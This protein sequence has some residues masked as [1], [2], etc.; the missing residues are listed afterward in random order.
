MIDL[1][2][3][4]FS[5]NWLVITLILLAIV[6]RF[7]VAAQVFYNPGLPIFP[8]N[9]LGI[10]HEWIKQGVY[11]HP[12]FGPGY[13][14]FL[15]GL[16]WVPIP[17][18]YFV[19]FIVVIQL[20]LS[21]VTILLSYFITIKMTNSKRVATIVVGLLAID[22]VFII[23]PSFIFTEVWYTFLIVLAFY[24]ML[25]RNS[26]KTVVIAG[27]I[28]GFSALV[29]GNGLL[30]IP[31]FIAYMFWVKRN[32]FQSAT[33]FLIAL[34]PLLFW[35]YQNY[36]HHGHFSVTASG[37]YN[38]ASLMIGRAKALSESLPMY[39]GLTAWEALMEKSHD[40][41]FDEAEAVKKLALKWAKEHPYDLLKWV[42][43]AQAA[44]FVGFGESQWTRIFGEV[45][46]VAKI[47]FLSYKF[48][49]FFAFLLGSIL[50][51]V[52]RHPPYRVG[53]LFILGVIAAHILPAGAGSYSRFLL[54]AYPFYFMVAAIGFYW[55]YKLLFFMISLAIPSS[56]QDP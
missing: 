34:I 17:E 37:N 19:F 39:H 44:T 27:F 9:Y 53:L 36:Q 25:C 23:Y 16:L 54:P 32:F 8:D 38:T 21:V 22:P 51:L 33:A 11:N 6:L 41:A 14:L 45:H 28:L 13:P 29:R 50:I 7:V 18:Q 4:L 35:S 47:L 31:L 12:Y 56:R 10:T 5:R 26:W 3:H 43:Y 1:M 2:T 55:G 52:W 40:N 20:I 48:L 49:I 30:L 46:P 15:R 42:F 24:L